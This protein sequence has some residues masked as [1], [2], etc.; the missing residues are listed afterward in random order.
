MQIMEDNATSYWV[1]TIHR[2]S[3]HHCEDNPEGLGLLSAFPA[4]MP[5]AQIF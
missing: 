2:Y 1:A 4:G 5:M 3:K